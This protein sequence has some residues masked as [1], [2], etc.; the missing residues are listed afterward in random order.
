M[1][2]AYFFMVISIIYFYN[3]LFSQNQMH[4][5]SK[6]LYDCYLNINSIYKKLEDRKDYLINNY[7]YTTEIHIVEDIFFLLK[8]VPTMAYQ[9]F[10]SLSLFEKLKNEKDLEFG[11]KLINESFSKM[12][13]ELMESKII[14]ALRSRDSGTYKNSIYL[15]KIQNYLQDLLMIVINLDQNPVR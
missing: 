11:R 14:I 2:T 7:Q 15:D 10:V 1:K 5:T 8:P 6:D 12:E 13:V 3:P 4:Y 9:S